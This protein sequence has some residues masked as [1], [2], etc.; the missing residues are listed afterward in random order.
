[1]NS[2]VRVC[3][4]VAFKFS[5]FPAW[6]NSLS[7]LWV[8]FCEIQARIPASLSLTT[9]AVIFNSVAAH[10]NWVLVWENERKIV[11][12]QKRNK[13]TIAFSVV[14]LMANILEFQVH[15]LTFK[16]MVIMEIIMPCTYILLCNL[17]SVFIVTDQFFPGTLL[18]GGRWSRRKMKR[19][20]VLTFHNSNGPWWSTVKFWK[21]WQI[22]EKD[23]LTI[24]ESPQ[25]NFVVS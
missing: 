17:Q 12:Q 3:S 25:K 11:S 20:V 24:L 7:L 14:I 19:R 13:R 2:N 6:I 8:C 10:Q 23:T 1:M 18:S 4:I 9:L 21:C 15:D 5:V 16:A 22:V